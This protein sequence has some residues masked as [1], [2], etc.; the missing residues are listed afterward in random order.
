MAINRRCFLKGASVFAFSSGLI[1]C[2]SSSDK[3]DDNGGSQPE[4]DYTRHVTCP[5]NCGDRCSLLVTTEDG[6][7]T[8]FTGDDRHPVTAGT[9]CVKGHAYLQSVYS[10][11]RLQ[12]PLKRVGPRGPGARFEPVSWDEANSA[13]A[14]RLNAII[15]EHGGNSVLPYSYSGN[16]TIVAKCSANRFFNRIGSRN[17]ERNIC[18]SAGY[19]GMSSVLGEFNGPSPEDY[20]NTQCY[21]SWGTNE[22]STNIHHLKFIN[23]AR[24]NGA[25][26]LVIN[27]AR[28]PMAS[29]A[30]IW[31]Q[32]TPGTDAMLSLGICKVLI[33]EN[34]HDTDFIS[35]YTQDFDA[36]E[37]RVQ[38]FSHQEIAAKTGVAT[39]DYQAFA[40]TYAAAPSAMI[41]IGYGLQRTR[42]GGR[43]VRSIPLL[44]GLTGN[45]GRPGA[46]V[47]Y[48]NVQGGAAMDWGFANA[49]HLVPEGAVRD[50]VSI[51]DIGKALVPEDYYH[52]DLDL[53]GPVSN[54]APVDP[55]KAM[56]VY[57]S[58]PMAIAPNT[59]L[60]EKGLQREDLFLV[61]L[62][63][64]MTD[65]MEYMD[66][67]L[68]TTSFIEQE[69]M[70]DSYHAY[71]TQHS[72]K[73]IEPLY[74]TR[75]DLQIF[76]GLAKAMGFSEPEFSISQEDLVEGCWNGS[77]S[78]DEFKQ[79]GFYTP[80]GIDYPWRKNFDWPTPSGKLEFKDASGRF[81]D[82]EQFHP[83][84]DVGTPESDDHANFG[85]TEAE[86]AREFRLL[87]PAHAK[88]SNSQWGN[89]KY[90]RN[91]PA[92]T[93]YIHPDDAAAK[94]IQTG[95]SVVLTASRHNDEEA[96][97]IY[98]AK[99]EPM[100]AAGTLFVWKCAWK[101]TNPNG[102]NTAINM[103]TNCDLTDMARGSSFHATRV[104]I[105]HA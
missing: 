26:I 53:T 46:G 22:Q 12:Q 62:D 10:P 37:A 79:Q 101:K 71:Y 94:G 44:A 5:R 85:M 67:I 102:T 97:I 103:I 82:P 90:T 70:V 80:K 95:D 30:D 11:D 99:V 32:P 55:I 75:T 36:L 52:K 3:D 20:V 96:S 7:A 4:F 76:Q 14:A 72:H 88:M 29:Q 64:F 86:K 98:T 89:I 66:Y 74:Q 60:I 48:L 33:E 63:L 104:D 31:L 34:L 100:T 42:N 84:I 6:V 51:N 39:R 21:V 81:F 83:V 35:K 78:Y 27:S 69:D 2:S 18:A 24:D 40:R 43:I 41:R 65:T 73:Q 57:S 54:G 38:D 58:N 61:G 8:A 59:Q 77:V 49:N 47:V 68:P 1:G 23:Q 19:D 15:G 16:N 25:K 56:I 87:S 13:I 45:F 92:H 28:T 17:L 91:L 9:P 105:H 50:T 93:L